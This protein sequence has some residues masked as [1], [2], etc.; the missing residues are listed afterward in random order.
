MITSS[1]PGHFNLSIYE[2]I[3]ELCLTAQRPGSPSLMSLR[4]NFAP[5]NRL[6]PLLPCPASQM[7]EL[8]LRQ[9]HDLSPRI[10]IKTVSMVIF[11]GSVPTQRM[12]LE[13]RCKCGLITITPSQKQVVGLGLQV[14]RE[15]PRGHLAF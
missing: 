14:E 4:S 2:T 13:W 8:R 11:K 5:G 6:H 1:W 9:Q 10:V 7:D 12:D 3:M 15:L